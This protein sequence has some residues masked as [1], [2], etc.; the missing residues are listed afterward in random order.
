MK[1][2]TFIGEQGC[3]LSGG[4]K[5]RIAIAR[6]IINDP[7]VLIADEATSALDLENEM[8]V[9]N[10]LNDAIKGKTC[11]LIAH[12]LATISKAKYIYVFDSGEIIESGSRIELIEKKGVFFNLIEPKKF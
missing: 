5:Q 4:Q 1:K 12:R 3:Q 2:N 11:I 9:Q 8:K 10:A 6:A 7:I